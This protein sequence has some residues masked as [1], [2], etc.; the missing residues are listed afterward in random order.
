MG[1]STA[2]LAKFDTSKENFIKT[3]NL[4]DS[5]YTLLRPLGEGKFKQLFRSKEQQ[6]SFNF[7][8]QCGTGA[9]LP[10]AADDN[11]HEVQDNDVL[12]LA[13]DGMYDNLYDEDV[14][15]CVEPKP[16]SIHLPFDH[17][18]IGECLA[19]MA[20][21]LGEMQNYQSP[22]AKNAQAVGRNYPNQGKADDIAVIVA[23]VHKKKDKK[24][25][26]KVDTNAID[27]DAKQRK[28][29][30]EKAKK[31]AKE[32]NVEEEIQRRI[33]EQQSDL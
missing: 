24:F 9:E 21:K 5:G 20:L 13:S 28:E 8:Y 4:G 33:Q 11:E 26:Q 16:D 27:S 6:Y 22:F 30:E 23:T 17:K 15:Y 2:V 29:E 25:D 7:P 1:S 32:V 3:T 12:I 14:V 31:Q 10:Y 19:N 18:R